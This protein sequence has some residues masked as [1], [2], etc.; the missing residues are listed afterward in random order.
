MNHTPGPWVAGLAPRNPHPDPPGDKW[1]IQAAMGWWVADIY[2]YVRGCQDDS[3]TR[4]NARLIAAAPDLLTACE[5]LVHAVK[6]DDS[7]LGGV[8]ATLAAE[9][10]IKATMEPPP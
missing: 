5:A 10:I 8:A 3:E 9:A 7:A 2:P 4:A 1:S 6:L